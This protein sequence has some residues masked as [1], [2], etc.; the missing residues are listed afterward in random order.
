MLFELSDS[1]EAVDGVTG[2]PADGLSD[3]KVNFAV[4]SI[5]HHLLEAV[6]VLGIR[7]RDALVG[8]NALWT[9]P[10]CLKNRRVPYLS[11]SHA[12]TLP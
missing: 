1:R 3:N 8:V 2:K 5:L 4:Q 9:I 6:T 11:Q 7:G 10:Q 12:V